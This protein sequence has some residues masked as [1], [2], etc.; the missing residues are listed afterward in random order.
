M[1]DHL[2]LYPMQI[3]R[4]DR[5]CIDI[6]LTAE[7]A[8]AAVTMAEMMVEDGALEHRMD[9]GYEGCEYE[10]KRSPSIEN[11]IPS[12][13]DEVPGHPISDWQWEV[14]ENHTRQGYHDWVNN[15]KA[16]IQEEEKDDV[17]DI[18]QADSSDNGV[19]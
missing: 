16:I 14:T 1:S 3:T 13:W 15:R 4:I 9:K 19:T 7:S 6:N 10:I 5:H 2:F 8:Q 18:Q 17:R 12:I 11:T